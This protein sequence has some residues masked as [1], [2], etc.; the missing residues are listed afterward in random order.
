MIGEGLQ[1]ARL[2]AVL[3]QPG[4]RVARD[5]AIY[6]METDKAVMDVESPHAGTVVRW[7]AE[8]DTV[9]P[10]GAEVMVMDTEEAGESA[11]AQPSAAAAAESAPLGTSPAVVPLKIP[12]IGEGLQEAR[13]VAVLKQPGDMVKRDEPIYQMETDKAV[14]DVEAPFAGKLVRWLAEVDTV[15]AIGA[16]VAMMEVEGAA[17]AATPAGESVAAAPVQASAP[18][19][20]SVGSRR[21]DVPPRTRAYA[22]SK[23]ISDDQLE[24]IAAA[25]SKLMPDDVDRFLSGGQSAPAVAPSPAASSSG[26]A[27]TETP[28]SGKQRVLSSRLVRGNQIV[29]P[30]MMTVVVDWGPIEAARAKYKVAGGDFQPSSFTIFA[31]AVAKAAAGNPIVRSTLVGDATVRTYEH[32]QLG[33]AVSLPDDDL[34]VAVVED[35]SR[36]SW[37]EFADQARAKIDLARGGKDQANESVTLSITNMQAFGIREAMAVVVPPGV[38]T[39][40]LGEPYNGLAQDTAEL[41]FQRCA[42]VGITIDH[43]L[44]NGVPGATFL[45]DIKRNVEAISELIGD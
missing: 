42:N 4:D 34:V 9:L 15:L 43:R 40:F 16:D 44:I 31:Y 3:K 24:T 36:L 35:A 29:V 7:L 27:F 6:Q 32:L 38:A 19:A 1:E 33:I 8:V 12:M 45:Q 2:V 37:R 25:G 13:L 11:V 20:V 18:A 17:P 5:E 26:K 14:M 30:G 23:G 21:R 41:K 28:L 10:I 39:I 22:R